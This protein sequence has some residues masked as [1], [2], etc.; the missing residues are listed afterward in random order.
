MSSKVSVS[1]LQKMF[2]SV[3]QSLGVGGN[4]DDLVYCC[5]RDSTANV[6]F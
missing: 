2:C 6:H 4:Y 5:Q 1:L 3:R